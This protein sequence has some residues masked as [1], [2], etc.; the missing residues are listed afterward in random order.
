MKTNRH[1]TGSVTLKAKQNKVKNLPSPKM[2]ITPFQSYKTNFTQL[3]VLFVNKDETYR[4]STEKSTDSLMRVVW[5]FSPFS[6][7]Y[8]GNFHCNPLEEGVVA[9]LLLVHTYTKGLALWSPNFFCGCFS[10][11]S[12]FGWTL[13]FIFNPSTLF[14]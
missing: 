12:H 9:D 8:Q 4:V 5:L 10:G 6:C 11:P 13:S 2:N 1:R 14:F 3:N 7:S